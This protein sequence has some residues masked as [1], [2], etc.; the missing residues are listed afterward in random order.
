[1]TVSMP[2]VSSG[3]LAAHL[4]DKELL[5]CDCRFAGDADSSRE[6]YERGHVPGAIHVYWLDDLAA[7]DTTVTTFLPNPGQAA[8]G[9]RAARDHAGEDGGRLFGR[10]EPV[11][12]A[13]V[14]CVDALRP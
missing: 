9:T 10:W 14:A 4:R 2:L 11:R 12:V 6:S 1:M 3:Q 7:A 5:V 13:A 8:D